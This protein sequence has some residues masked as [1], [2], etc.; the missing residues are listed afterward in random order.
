MRG[1]TDDSRKV[2]RSDFFPGLGWMMT[3][4][5]WRDLDVKWPRGYW[6]DWLREP[7]NRKGRETIRPDVSRTFH[8]GQKGGTSNNVYSNYLDSIVL[9]DADVDWGRE[10]LGYLRKKEYD[11]E[12]RRRVEWARLVGVGEVAGA[13]EARGGGGER[14]DEEGC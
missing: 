12:F 3:R 13:G 2:V 14:S 1:F 9:N 11:K 10:D 7:V 4:D 6:D 5:V 8:F